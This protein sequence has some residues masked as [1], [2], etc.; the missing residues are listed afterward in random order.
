MARHVKSASIFSQKVNE[1]VLYLN[2][3]KQ[4]IEISSQDQ[5][6]GDYHSILP[7]EIEGEEVTLTFNSGYLLDG[8]LGMSGPMLSIKTNQGASPIL[9][10]SAEYDGFRYVLMP[11]KTQ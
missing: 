1:V 2:Q 9:M 3:K 10:S 4:Q 8:I 11:I 6:R 7:C 5:E